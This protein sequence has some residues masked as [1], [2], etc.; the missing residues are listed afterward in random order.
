MIT[1]EDFR[2]KNEEDASLISHKSV[3]IDRKQKHPRKIIL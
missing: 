2:K 1:E 3:M